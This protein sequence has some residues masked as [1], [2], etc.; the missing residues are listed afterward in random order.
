MNSNIKVF[1]KYDFQFDED[2]VA[3]Y[4]KII[5][6]LVYLSDIINSINLYDIYHTEN[7]HYHVFRNVTREINDIIRTCGFPEI[8]SHNEYTI[9]K[10]WWW[11]I[12]LEDEDK[13]DYD[14]DEEKYHKEMNKVSSEMALDYL[15]SLEIY[16]DELCKSCTEFMISIIPNENDRLAYKQMLRDNLY[17]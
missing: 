9:P 12:Q 7:Y 8:D 5:D 14:N 16:M 2:M 13:E 6:R 17:K 4:P 1:R 11:D 15:N 10:D 3:I